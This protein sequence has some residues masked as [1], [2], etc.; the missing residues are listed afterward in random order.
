MARNGNGKSNGNGVNLAPNITVT[1]DGTILTV[2]T[3]LSVTVETTEKGGERI[4]STKGWQGF[5]QVMIDGQEYMLR[6]SV[7]RPAPK[8]DKARVSL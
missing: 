6:F 5:M 7:V 1:R 4:A 3:D 8:A 2:S